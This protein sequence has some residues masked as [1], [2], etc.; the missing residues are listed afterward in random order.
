MEFRNSSVLSSGDLHTGQQ[1]AAVKQILLP[2]D[3][4]GT[5]RNTTTHF[6]RVGL[7]P[8]V[9]K[10]PSSGHSPSY[11]E[12]TTRGRLFDDTLDRPAGD[13]KNACHAHTLEKESSFSSAVWRNIHSSRCEVSSKASKVSHKPRDGMFMSKEDFGFKCKFGHYT[14]KLQCLLFVTVLMTVTISERAQ[15]SKPSCFKCGLARTAE[16]HRSIHDEKLENL[17]GGNMPVASSSVIRATE[18]REFQVTGAE[19]ASID[20]LGKGSE[21]GPEKGLTESNEKGPTESHEKG[22][23]E[24]LEK[25]PAES[26]EKGPRESH[27]KGPRES[28]ENGPAEQ[29]EVCGPRRSC[30]EGKTC[31]YRV[32]GT[33]GVCTDAVSLPCVVNGTSYEDGTSFLLDCRTECTCTGG[34]YACVSLCPEEAL[35]PSSHCR[36][37]ALQETGQQCCRQWTC[38]PDPDA[39]APGSSRCDVT[40]SRWSACS[41]LSCGLGLS[42]RWATD[43]ITCRP[44]LQTR[45]CQLRPCASMVSAEPQRRRRLI[46]RSHHCKATLRAERAE[47]LIAGPCVSQRRYRAKRCN[48]CRDSCCAAFVDTSLE[49]TFLCPLHAVPPYLLP[50]SALSPV[51]QAALFEAATDPDTHEGRIGDLTVAGEQEYDNVTASNYE[52]VVKRVQWILRCRC[53]PTCQTPTVLPTTSPTWGPEFEYFEAS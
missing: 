40:V 25:G 16:L 35:P 50:D 49:V 6:S 10:W 41:S 7:R 53:T 22:P 51:D 8:E 32:P 34:A 18:S 26:H 14:L 19:A 11:M 27:E 46:R 37:P 9:E 38:D 45:L 31:R 33:I 24:S 42:Q 48:S 43:S 39:M 15:A 28:H 17:G 44:E 29:E 21:E 52:V 23:T 4:R 12:H 3:R 36:N 2:E 13:I 20:F 47:R 5:R 30:P 1:I